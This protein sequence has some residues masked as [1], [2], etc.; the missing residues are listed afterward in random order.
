LDTLQPVELPVRSRNAFRALAAI[1]V[2]S[3]AAGALLAPDRMWA[4][5]L[6]VSYYALGLGL[7]G[8]CLVAIHFATGSSWSVAVRRVP[9]AL[10]GTIP[11]AAVALIVMLFERPQLYPWSHGDFGAARETAL[12]FKR[13]WLSRPFFIARAIIDVAIWVLFALAIRRN[14]Q[15]QDQDGDLKWT[16]AN[17]RLSAAFLVLFAVTFTLASFDWVMSLEPAWFSTIFGVYNFA[18]LMLAGL[19]STLIIAIW[20]ERAGPLRG[21]LTDDHL[22]DLGKLLFAFGTFWMYI[23]FCQ[24]MLIWYTDI[25]EETAYYVRRTQGAWGALFLL[26]IVLNWVVPFFGLIRRDAKRRRGLILAVCVVVLLGRWL[27]LYVMI[28]PAVLGESPSVGVWEIGMAAGAAGF[29]IL[30]LAQ[31]LRAAPVVPVRDPQL[32]ESLHY[33]SLH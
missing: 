19:A 32:V 9:E 17:V 24:Y 3:A 11:F 30:A 13:F 20:L 26:N 29:F 10:A 12:A 25:P 16:R 1:G 27:D 6:L 23:W 22:H 2:V 33:D 21:I 5:W 8:L 28:F 15:R 7:A 31:V 18:G 14:S 4:N